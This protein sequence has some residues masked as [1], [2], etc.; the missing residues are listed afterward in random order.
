MSII[1]I[2]LGGL[3]SSVDVVV[4][5]VVCVVIQNFRLVIFRDFDGGVVVLV[6]VIAYPMVL[7]D[8]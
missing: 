5:V 8:A 4:V 6:V 2:D 3:F 7:M 1:C